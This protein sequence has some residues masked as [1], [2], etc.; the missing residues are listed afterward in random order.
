MC[1]GQRPAFRFVERLRIGENHRSQ[2]TLGDGAVI[3][4]DVRG[5]RRA[6]R[7][8]EVIHSVTVWVDDAR[9][10]CK[11]AGGQGARIL[12]EPT[13]MPYSER[14]KTPKTSPATNGPSP[15]RAGPAWTVQYPGLRAGQAGSVS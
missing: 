4:G 11:H 8:G 1:A 15:R 5:D 3:A 12:I 6:P 14:H 7:T 9:T 10:R 2:F 13:D